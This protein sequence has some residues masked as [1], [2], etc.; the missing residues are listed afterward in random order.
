M[1]INASKSDLPMIYKVWLDVDALELNDS[2]L[3]WRD[4]KHTSVGFD[5]KFSNFIIKKF[6]LSDEALFKE[7]FEESVSGDGNE[8]TKIDALH[9]SSLCALLCFYN[10]KNH[11]LE[12]K[13]VTYDDA[14]FELKN[15]V[16]RTP[17][18]MDVVLTGK[19]GKG[20][21]AILFIECKFSEYLGNPTY[22][23]GKTYSEEPYKHIFD[24]FEY[25]KQ[26]VFQYGLK[27]LVTHYIGIR[28]FINDDKYKESMS[29][30]YREN[31][32]RINLYR[33]FDVVSFAEVVFEL[34]NENKYSSYLEATKNV[35]KVLEKEK[36]KDGLDLNLLGTITYQYLF[37]DYLDGRNSEV[38]EDKV[39]AFYK[40]NKRI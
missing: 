22:K 30:Y 17:S 18:N 39:R 29:H 28:H 40:L 7:K 8:I 9:S 33:K 19:D 36:I 14:H 11:P 35:F 15:K 12:Y 5:V 23:L 13:G 16:E 3:Y 21:N 1:G 24:G 37:R 2:D 25:E 4:L 34:P 10:V 6:D 27:Q 31:D 20:K 32:P 26:K 38:L